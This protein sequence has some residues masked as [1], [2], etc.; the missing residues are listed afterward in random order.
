MTTPAPFPAPRANGVAAP[1]RWIVFAAALLL[2]G[3][4]GLRAQEFSLLYGSTTLPNFKSSTYAW[5]V[6]YSQQLYRNFSGSI[7]WL[8]EG[9]I[10]GHHRDGTAAQL[11]LD[12]PM[13]DG[14]Y[15]LSLGG[16]G[17]YYFDTQ[18]LANGDTLDVH[19]TAP[20]VSLSATAYISDRWFARVLFNRVNPRDN[21][22]SNTAMLGFGYWYGQDKRPKPGKLGAPPDEKDFV[23]GNE[24]T[25]YSG[26]SI[27]NAAGNLQGVAAALEYRR[28]FMRHLDAT[29][30][31]I[32]EGD[33]RIVRRS[34]LAFQVWPVNTFFDDHVT[35]GIGLGTYIYVDNKHL[36]ASRSLPGG[37]S[38]NTPALAP[39]ISPT[40]AVN[41]SDQWR[42]RAVW[43]RVVTNY[44]RDSD[45]ILLG[46]GYRWR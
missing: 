30:S 18:F 41:L 16:G 2:G 13:N 24:L 7:A 5:Q 10:P 19:G 20:I 4:G 14:R 34:G 15:T 40:F 25:L 38:V 31:F 27:V 17:Y 29:A 23:T 8:N 9:H 33:P 6:D 39:L 36:G 35:F 44:N 3:I 26:I 22:R 46:L 1:L 43:N 42:V 37:G 21:F 11:W 12:F 28:G 45:V 32:H